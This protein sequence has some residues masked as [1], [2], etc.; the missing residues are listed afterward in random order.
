[1]SYDIDYLINKIDYAVKCEKHA[2]SGKNKYDC[3]AARIIT[4]RKDKDT[5]LELEELDKIE[6]IL[7]IPDKIITHED[8]KEFKGKIPEMFIY[9]TS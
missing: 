2:L 8:Y 1:M 9:S 4:L 7:T 5:F 6:V 3:I